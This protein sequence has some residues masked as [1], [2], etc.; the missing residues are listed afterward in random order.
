MNSF[1]IDILIGEEEISELLEMLFDRYGYDFRDYSKASLRR[2]VS[3]FMMLEKMLGLPQFRTR[4]MEEE[5]FFWYFLNEIT[6]NVTEMFRDPTFFRYLRE[7]VVPNLSS[8]PFIRIWFAGCSSGEEVYSL[9]IILREEGLL[10]RSLL[11]ATDINQNVLEKAQKG[12]YSIDQVRKYQESYEKA[13]GKTQLLDYFSVKSGKATI[14]EDLKKRVVF[15][16]HN[17]VADQSFNEFNLILCRNVLIYFNREL[18]NRVIGLFTESLSP[19]GYLALGSKETLRFTDFS[20]EYERLTKK[21]KVW[22][23]KR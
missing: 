4:L 16:H 9:A 13:G 1:D 8:F 18:Q 5:A 3:R 15:S 12:I 14:D 2:R 11:Y 19:L 20:D 17:L 6:V 10:E 7:Q 21:E 22:R 23:K